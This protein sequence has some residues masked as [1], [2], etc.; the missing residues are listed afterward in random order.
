MVL[1]NLCAGKEWRCR[2]GEWTCGH[3]EGRRG[4]MNGENST[5]IYT[6]SCVKQIGSL[7]YNTGGPARNGITLAT[8]LNWHL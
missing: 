1:R 7:L 3:S 5:D 6:L 8:G 2:C 4:G